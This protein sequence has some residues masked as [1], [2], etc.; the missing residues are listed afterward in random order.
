VLAGL[1]ICIHSAGFVPAGL[2]ELPRSAA[3]PALLRGPANALAS[4]IL[5]KADRL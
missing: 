1:G 4:A 5:D 3:L 2:A